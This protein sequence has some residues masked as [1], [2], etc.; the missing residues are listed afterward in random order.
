[1][2]YGWEGERLGVDDAKRVIR[3]VDGIITYKHER[4]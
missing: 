4:W 1:M 2:Y 3:C